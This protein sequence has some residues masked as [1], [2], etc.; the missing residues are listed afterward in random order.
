LP[1]DAF[2]RALGRA[3]DIIIPYQREIG[4]S[5]TL[6]VKDLPKDGALAHALAP[7]LRYIAGEEVVE[8]HHSLLSRLLG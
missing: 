2:A 3:P 8:E 7:V 1:F 4:L 6:G 5:S